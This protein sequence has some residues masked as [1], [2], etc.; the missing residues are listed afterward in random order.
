MTDDD[1]LRL[2]RTLQE[3]GS[4]LDDIEAK[5]AQ[6][7]IP[8]ALWE[9]ISALANRPPG[10]VL[11]FGL[12]PGTFYPTGIADL[13]QLQSDVSESKPSEVTASPGSWIALS[14]AAPTSWEFH[15][16]SE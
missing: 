7:G 6:G 14:W 5:S 8:G 4:D 2:V 12:D 15:C 1:V 9:T 13:D 11:L 16:P 3:K 10:G